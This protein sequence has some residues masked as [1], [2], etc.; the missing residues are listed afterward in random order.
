MQS[1]DARGHRDVM[2]PV[3]VVIWASL[4]ALAPSPIA[5]TVM[6]IVVILPA[7]LWWLCG[8]ADRWRTAFFAAAILLPPLPL[9]FGDS[10][11]HLA[12]V[13]AAIGLVVL[14]IGSTRARLRSE[15]LLLLLLLFLGA[16]L[17]S[18]VFA[19]IF[20]GTEIALM[21]LARIALFAIAPLIY[22][23]IVSGAPWSPE[24]S[25]R[26]ARTLYRL[27]IAAAVFACADFY[28]QFSSP[29]RYSAQFVWLEDAVLRRAQ[30]L[31]YEASTLGNFCVFFLVMILVVSLSRSEVRLCSRA[32]LAI[33]TI[34]LAAALLFSYS[35][36][37]ILNLLCA[38]AAFLTV[39]KR[40]S[41]RLIFGGAAAMVGVAGLVYL[42]LPSFSRTYW[43][44]IGVSLW[45]LPSA[46]GPILSGRLS[47]WQT[48]V[49][50][51]QQNPW[52]LL[53]GIGYKTLPYSSYL[54]KSVITDNTYLDLLVE[55]GLVGLCSFL[56]LNFEMLRCGLRAARSANPVAQLFGAWFFCF[57][58]GELVQMLSG[59]LITYWRVLPL[60]FC[61]LA[62]SQNARSHTQL[63]YSSR[64][65][66]TGSTL[67][68]R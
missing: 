5:K 61:V 64:K 8:A 57:W 33:G 13:F 56:A 45:L 1:V 15:R 24:R 62:V 43:L 2:G 39:R 26:M 40:A 3:A 22:V 67:A 68:A 25:F 10:G 46:P 36:A 7:L 29:V 14:L 65:A 42:I 32:E 27:A 4:I 30:G 50:F 34:V 21:S 37:S 41:K 17:Q 59:D 16:L 18:V 38:G 20:S 19:A 66:S 58:I 53:L 12:P 11:P 23:S 63:I 51:L 60:Y 52:H 47:S 48:L 28:F 9:A 31:F 55:T 49:A 54:G 44:R 6:L 35:R